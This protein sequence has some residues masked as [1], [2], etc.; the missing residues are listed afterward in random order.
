MQ[1][2]LMMNGMAAQTGMPERG[3]PYLEA[4]M[5]ASEGSE[6]ED[7]VKMRAYIAPDYALRVEKDAEKA[8]K[9]KL[10]GMDEG[11]QEDPNALNNMAWWCFENDVHLEEALAWAVKGVELAGS[12]GERANV[13]D[14]AA[15]LCN[16]LG[17]CDDAIA[18]IKKAIELDPENAYFKDQLAKFEKAAEEKKG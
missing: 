5:K 16:A 1:L 13:L 18:K 9:L 3:V 6:D 15:E 8:F 7:I 17:N 14:T 2:A 10:E 12:D 11:W 4:A